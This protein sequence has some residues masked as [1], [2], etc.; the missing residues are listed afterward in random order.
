MAGDAL[1]S[2]ARTFAQ[3]WFVLAALGASLCINLYLGLKTPAGHAQTRS[4]LG[5]GKHLGDLSVES[6]EGRK[7]YFRWA[8]DSRPVVLYVFSPDCA[9]CNRNLKN[10][11]ELHRQRKDSYRFVGISLTNTGLAEYVRLTALDFPVYVNAYELRTDGALAKFGV[12]G[13][14]ET[15]IVGPDGVVKDFWPG[16]YGGRIQE[17]IEAKIG[18]H[19]PGL[20]RSGSTPVSR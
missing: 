3:S 10:I 14:P 17:Q 4:S 5:I 6:P 9:W 7:A 19:L 12:T 13:T 16:A 2:R 1:L 15:A 20:P 8:D 18:V 11:R